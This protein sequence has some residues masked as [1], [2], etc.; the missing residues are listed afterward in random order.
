MDGKKAVEYRHQY[1][2]TKEIADGTAIIV[3]EMVFDNIGKDNWDT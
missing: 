3:C 2:I 1:G